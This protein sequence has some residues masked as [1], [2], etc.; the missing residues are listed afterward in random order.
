MR[1]LLPVAPL[2]VLALFALVP[3]HAQHRLQ[4]IATMTGRPALELA[5][6]KLDTVGNVMMTTAHPDDE[7]NALLAYYGHTKGFRTSLVTATRG[8][9]G[10]NEIGPAPPS[11]SCL[12]TRSST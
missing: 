11:A 8:E 12:A 7:N 5:L 4:P 3:T 10:Q 9:G 6:R 1:R 2:A